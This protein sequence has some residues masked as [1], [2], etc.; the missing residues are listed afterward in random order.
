MYLHFTVTAPTD[1]KTPDWDYIDYDGKFDKLE[2]LREAESYW[3]D[4]IVIKEWTDVDAGAVFEFDD[5]DPSLKKGEDY[6]YYA[7][8]TRQE[9]SG[10]CKY[11]YVMLGMKPID[12]DNPVLEPTGK[13]APVTVKYTC[14]ALE[15]KVGY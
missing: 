6:T 3:D 4:P 10:D 15:R 11:A 13:G 12:P 5:K 14:P 2:L 8:A 1:L 7:V 9:K